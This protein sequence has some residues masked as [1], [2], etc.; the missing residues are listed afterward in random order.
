M[1]ALKKLHR[2]MHTKTLVVFIGF[3][4]ILI[5]E[6]DATDERDRDRGREGA[7]VRL[8]MLKPNSFACF[9]KTYN[10]F[11]IIC[12]YFRYAMH[13]QL[14]CSGLTLPTQHLALPLSYKLS[15]SF[16]SGIPFSSYLR[17]F[18]TCYLYI[19]FFLSL[20]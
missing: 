9:D 2:I 12:V 7:C 14:L 6:M 17:Y 5:C 10:L 18:C 16:T 3:G 4:L 13:F 8:P 15:V 1:C 20:F 11:T 19:P